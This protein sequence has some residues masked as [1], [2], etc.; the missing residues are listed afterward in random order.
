MLGDEASSEVP[1]TTRSR[2][3]IYEQGSFIG[4]VPSFMEGDS[5]LEFETVVK[6]GYRKSSALVCFSR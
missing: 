4:S 2:K 1:P 5:T 3:S 6:K